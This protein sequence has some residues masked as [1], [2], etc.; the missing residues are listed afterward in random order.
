MTLEAETCS[1]NK[2]YITIVTLDI[3]HCSYDNIL[4]LTTA[5]DI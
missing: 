5:K 4:A 1:W 2:T 3:V